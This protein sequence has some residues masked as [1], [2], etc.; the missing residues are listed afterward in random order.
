MRCFIFYVYIKPANFRAY[1]KLLAYLSLDWPHFK[2]LVRHIP[3]SY[4]I[5][6]HRCKG[7]V[8]LDVHK[9]V[10]RLLWAVFHS[11]LD[12]NTVSW[13]L[14]LYLP[15]LSDIL[16][17]EQVTPNSDVTWIRKR[18]KRDRKSNVDRAEW[19]DPLFLL[20]ECSDC[21][22]LPK[23]IKCFKCTITVSLS[24]PYEV[25]HLHCS[26]EKM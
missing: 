12:A 2:C 17:G 16:V 10:I 23:K 3:N 1:F 9:D 21:T 25:T 8:L 18:S 13:P 15:V 14:W 7:Q 11:S 20:M 5:G 22:F 4:S 19:Y 6:Q 26:W 24:C